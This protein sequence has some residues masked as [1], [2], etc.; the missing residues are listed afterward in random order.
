MRP[1]I[2]AREREGVV[3]SRAFQK[4]T[5]IAAF[6]N[7]LRQAVKQKNRANLPKYPEYRTLRF[8]IKLS[9]AIPQQLRLPRSAISRNWGRLGV[10]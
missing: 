3:E 8:R 10:S 7:V 9:L 5:Q 1:A 2:D 4:T 6:A